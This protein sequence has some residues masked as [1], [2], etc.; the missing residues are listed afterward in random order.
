MF[1]LGLCQAYSTPAQD[2]APLSLFM[3]TVPQRAKRIF[4]SESESKRPR[5]LFTFKSPHQPLTQDPWAVFTKPASL[6][7]SGELIM[8]LFSGAG[9]VTSSG[10]WNGPYLHCIS[11]QKLPTR[12]LWRKP[13]FKSRQILCKGIFG[14]VLWY[15]PISKV[16]GRIWAPK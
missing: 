3:L 12:A 2:I 8:H 9:P 16:G 14:G 7:G 15:P 6:T 10:A 5:A 13:V 4:V 11:P 1:I